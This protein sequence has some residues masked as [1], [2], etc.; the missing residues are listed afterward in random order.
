[1][2][3]IWCSATFSFQHQ[4]QWHQ[5][6]HYTRVQ[7]IL[8]ARCLWEATSVTQQVVTPAAAWDLLRDFLLNVSIF[9]CATLIVWATFGINRHTLMHLKTIWSYYQTCQYI[10]YSDVQF[11]NFFV[12]VFCL[13]AVV[14]WYRW[15]EGCRV[16]L[17]REQLPWPWEIWST[18]IGD[19]DGSSLPGMWH[20]VIWQ[21]Q[22]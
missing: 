4:R 3:V 21:V 7:N 12:P 10:K 5:S 20:N 18:P 22:W 8:T 2:W 14:G 13:L 9:W 15:K 19:A 16:E 17:W 6:Y 1:M 11:V